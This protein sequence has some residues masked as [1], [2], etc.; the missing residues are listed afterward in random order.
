MQTIPAAWYGPERKGRE[1]WLLN[2]NMGRVSRSQ[3][4]FVRANTCDVP[5]LWHILNKHAQMMQTPCPVL[6]HGPCIHAQ[7]A[8][9][10]EASSASRCE[11]AALGGTSSGWSVLCRGNN[12]TGLFPDRLARQTRRPFRFLDLS[13]NNIRSALLP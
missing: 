7:A 12:L 1:W 10:L 2:L 13:N 5:G 11:S 3:P 9:I 8:Y 6:L 4:Q